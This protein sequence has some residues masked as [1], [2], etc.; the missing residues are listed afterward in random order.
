VHRDGGGSDASWLH[1]DAMGSRAADYLQG[2]VALTDSVGEAEPSFVVWPRS[3]RTIFPTICPGPG[4]DP[5]EVCF[6]VACKLAW[7]FG[8]FA[9][10]SQTTTNIQWFMG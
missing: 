6:I 8:G 4:R 7:L 2:L 3:H 10:S 1:F 9:H 5:K